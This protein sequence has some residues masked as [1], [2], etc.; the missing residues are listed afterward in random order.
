M[1]DDLQ[2]RAINTIRFL[3]AD[4]VQQANSGHPGLP[5]GAA[6]M[7][8]ALWTRHLRHNPRNPKWMGRDRF[9]LSGGHGSM[10]LYSLLH[11]TGYDVGLDQIKNFRQW[12]SIT[13]GHPEYGLTPGVETT[14]GPLGQGFATGVGMA[15]AQAH[16]A[17]TFNKPGHEL[18]QSYIYGIVTDGD[19]MEGI[20]SEAASMAGH[21][22][23]GRLIYLY[24]DNHIS[25]DGSTDLAFTENRNARFEAYGWHVQTVED[26]NDV[27]A[28]DQ[29]IQNAKKDP[30]PS[31]ISVRTVIG[32]G[33]PQK[34]GTA[35]AHGEPLGK[36]ELNAA[37]ENLGWPTEPR[38]HIPDDVLEFYRKAV[39]RGRELEFDWK[40]KFDAYKNLHPKLGAELARRLAGKLPDDWDADLPTF[41]AD[42]KGMATRKSSGKVLDALSEKMPELLGGSAD[43]TPSNNTKFDEA[44]DFQKENPSSRYLHFGVREHA[45]G[46]AL[47]GMNVFGGIIAYGGTFLIFSDYM[48]PAIRIAALSYIP[49]I[50]V[51]T[52]DSIGLGED[53]PTHQPVEHLMALRATPNLVVIR[54]ADA[55]EV[56]EAWKVAISRRDGPTALALTRQTVPTLAIGPFVK[57]SRGAYV[58]KDFGENPQLILMASGSEVN[59][60]YSAAQRL[61]AEG[62]ETR[63]V[64]FPSWEL[65]EKQDDAYKESVLPQKIQVRLA[66]EAGAR[67]GWERYAKSIIGID[68]YGASAPGEI[69]LEKFG[70]TVENVVAKAQELVK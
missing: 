38:F 47:N 54:P 24:D 66:V 58:M 15:I 23:L 62:I 45:M 41:P 4:A 10:L 52:H 22:S 5:M 18:I 25:I 49:S 51:F 16:L 21:L 37:K 14:T 46:A 34:Q 32:F 57:L 53:G 29:A 65:F 28:V 63:V 8:F 36:E 30:R 7:A 70:F 43:L 11:L 67:L 3:S 19:L 31:L 35:K 61:F 26:G 56:C 59:L 6:A 68:H 69:V 33:A 64:S 20:S 55:N 48:K 44:D 17:A 12:E 1:T 40:M 50:F 2:T 39:E 42:E 9:V 27:E 13:P 60:I